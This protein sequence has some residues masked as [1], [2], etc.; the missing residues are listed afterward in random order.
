MLGL[1]RGCAGALEKASSPHG[2]AGR[3]LGLNFFFTC[4]NVTSSPCS[5]IAFKVTVCHNWEITGLQN[6]TYI[7]IYRSEE[8]RP[9]CCVQISNTEKVLPAQGFNKLC[10]RRIW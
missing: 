4:R 5:R 2:L 1:W 9:L 3:A 7:Y 8:M 10:D 6:H